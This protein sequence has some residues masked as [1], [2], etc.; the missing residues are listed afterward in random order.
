MNSKPKFA[1]GKKVIFKC[2][3][4]KITHISEENGTYRY[5]FDE[6]EYF[7]RGGYYMPSV[8]LQLSALE[9]ELINAQ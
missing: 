6:Y 1:V 2:D 7:D 8:T 9:S 3:K 5:F 4:H